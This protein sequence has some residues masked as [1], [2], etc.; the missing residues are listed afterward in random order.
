MGLRSLQQKTQNKH[1]ER[2]D[3]VGVDVQAEAGESLARATGAF[4]LELLATDLRVH[5]Q[6]CRS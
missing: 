6:F 1:N 3:D 2:N 4:P 5:H